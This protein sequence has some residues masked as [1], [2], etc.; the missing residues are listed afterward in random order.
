MLASLL[1]GASA[2][3]A[4]YHEG[5]GPVTE[6]VEG[7]ADWSLISDP[8]PVFRFISSAA[9][10]QFRCVV[11]ESEVPCSG[12]DHHVAELPDGFHQF[13]VASADGGGPFGEPATRVFFIDTRAPDTTIRYAIVKGGKRLVA[14]FESS[15][16]GTRFECRLAT[17]K[18]RD[19]SIPYRR[20]L[21]KK[22]RKP[23]KKFKLR[24]RAVDGAGNRDPSPA[25]MRVRVPRR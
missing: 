20:K 1:V 3:G 21:P 10:P 16:G 9:N 12:P 13:S 11:N 23:G 14:L 18:W 22:L 15:E 24:A 19:C 4:D 8:A 2:A 17:G 6:I 25:K 5:P 7:P